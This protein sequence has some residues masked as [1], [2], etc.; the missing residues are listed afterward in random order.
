[1]HQ[2]EKRRVAPLGEAISEFRESRLNDRLSTRSRTVYLRV[3]F[4]ER[5]DSATESFV[6]ARFFVRP[7]RSRFDLSLIASHHESAPAH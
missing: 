3:R 6:P 1:M 7:C 5:S 4:P 2:L